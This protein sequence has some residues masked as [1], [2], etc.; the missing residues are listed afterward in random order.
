[1]HYTTTI[2]FA[3]SVF[4]NT[5]TMFERPRTNI[6]ILT[7]SII[8]SLASLA[9]GWISLAL[10]RLTP[11]EDRSCTAIG[12]RTDPINSFVFETSLACVSVEMSGENFS[13]FN[14]L[15]R[16]IPT[17]ITLPTSQR[18]ELEVPQDCTTEVPCEGETGTTCSSSKTSAGSIPE[19]PAF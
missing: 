7:A 12:A 1:M 17:V 4:P 8:R 14:I 16:H 2:I 6:L 9:G 5:S 11:S 3:F 13:Y 15:T 18:R 10:S 19:P